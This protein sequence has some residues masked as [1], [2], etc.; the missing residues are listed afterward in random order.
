MK[1]RDTTEI[2]FKNWTPHPKEYKRF[3]D[4]ISFIFLKYDDY[5]MNMMLAF[6]TI[7]NYKFLKLYLL[8]LLIK[9]DFTF[10]TEHIN[11]MKNNNKLHI[12]ILWFFFKQWDIVDFF[13]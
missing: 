10:V 3:S 4:Y 1:E 8:F 6:L 13:Q 7:S 2:V 11:W 9:M 5:K 12:L